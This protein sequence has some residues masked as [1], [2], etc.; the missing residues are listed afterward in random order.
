M[1]STLIKIVYVSRGSR[2]LARQALLIL[3]RFLLSFIL[4]IPLVFFLIVTKSRK[5]RACTN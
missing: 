1:R 3:C 4:P 5:R 2:D